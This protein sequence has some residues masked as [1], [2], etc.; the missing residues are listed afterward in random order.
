VINNICHSCEVDGGARTKSFNL[1]WATPW[2]AATNIT[3]QCGKV[4]KGVKKLQGI[5]SVKP[6]AI[7]LKNGWD[8]KEC[9][10]VNTKKE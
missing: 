2:N 5:S 10:R 4:K 1:G 6:R 9:A 8:E 3:Q 7:G